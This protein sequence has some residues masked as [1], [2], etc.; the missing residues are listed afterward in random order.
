MKKIDI[1]VVVPVYKEEEI[2]EE[3]YNQL[4][5]IMEE[6]KIDFE[7]IFVHDD[8]SNTETM[9]ILKNIH[10]RDP[11][12]VI[13]G[14]ARNFGHQIALTAGIDYARGKAVVMLDGDLQHPPELIITLIEYWRNGYDIVY[15]IRQDVLGET[16]FKKLSAKIFYLLMSKISN[17]DMGINC[18]DFRL[19]SRKAVDGF[20]KMNEKSRFIRGLV[21]WMGYKK[22]GINYIAQARS[23][24]ETK[25]TLKK[26]IAFALDGILLFS[27]FPIRVISLVGLIISFTSFFYIVRV[28]YFVL[29]EKDKIPDLLPITSIILFLCGIQMVMLGVIG[30]YVAKIFTESKNRPLYLIDEIYDKNDDRS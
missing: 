8:Y 7:I 11:R 18:A 29:F 5:K 12:V 1:S 2:V 25:Y 21:S 24:G 14:L 30:E 23:K 19:M 16:F 22:I 20:K 4:I 15:T 13:I 9:T 27:N 3:F 17:V 26:I 6:I 28:T 10:S